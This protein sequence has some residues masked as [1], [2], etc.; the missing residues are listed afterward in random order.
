MARVQQKLRL[1]FYYARA[2]KVTAKNKGWPY[3]LRYAKNFLQKRI[4]NENIEPKAA[5]TS[6]FQDIID[7]L[8]HSVSRRPLIL[9]ISDIQ[10]RQCIHYRIRQKERYLQ[11]IGFQTMSISPAH[12]GRMHAFVNFAHTVIIYRTYVKPDIVEKFKKL[13]IR[14][15]FEFDDLIVGEE[16]LKSSGILTNLTERQNNELIRRAGQFLET[17]RACDDIIVSTPYLADQYAY[18]NNLLKGRS[19]HIV[20]NFV[21]T[22][23]YKRDENKEVTF[24]YTSPAGSIHEELRM[25]SSFLVGYDAASEHGW[26]IL[27]MGNSFAHR[28]LSEINFRAGNVLFQPF[29]SFEVYLE[30]LSSAEAV[31]IPL[32]DNRFN[33]SKTPIRL[34]DAAISG[35]QALFS[36]VGAYQDIRDVLGDQRLC[37]ASDNWEDIGGTIAPVL[38]QKE[39]NLAALQNAVHLLHGREAALKCYRE[40]FIEQMGLQPQPQVG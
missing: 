36:P 30:T 32:A 21:E 3:A 26:S 4:L 27:V 14:V 31:L 19:I 33:R 29:T 25:I 11:E 22:T 6:P 17:A 35:T 16:V 34:M 9:I 18:P 10:I 15:I 12:Q 28:E 5:E 23:T 20:P 24:A 38:A 40:V 13:G 2:F 1:A 7:S 37:I 39:E 8:P